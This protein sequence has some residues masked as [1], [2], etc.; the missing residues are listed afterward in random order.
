MTAALSFVEASFGYGAAEVLRGIDLSLAEGELLAV[1][2]ANGGGKTTL[3]RGATGLLAPT[4]GAVLVHGRPVAGRTRNE[5][6]REVAVV[7][8]EGTPIFPFSVLETVLMGRAP[9][10]RPFQFEGE[11]DLRRA[12]RALEQVDALALADRDL[13]ELSGG[14]RQRVIVARALAQESRILLADEPTAHLDLKHAVRLF[15]LLADLASGCRLATLVVTHDVNLAAAHC[16]RIVLL[17]EGRIVADGPP[18]EALTPAHLERT[19]GTR[20]RVETAD[21]GRILVVPEV[22]P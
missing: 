21:D 10:M 5:L 18:R 7:P 3:V 1:L 19:F 12:R 11:E 14:E 20:V 16:D 17:A 9:W 8:Q 6:A 15:R 4:A 22:A 13:T 2:G